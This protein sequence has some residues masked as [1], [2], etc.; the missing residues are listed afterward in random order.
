MVRGRQQ[1][2]RETAHAREIEARR[3][4]D[5]ERRETA[6]RAAVDRLLTRRWGGA[7]SALDHLSAVSRD[8]EKLHRDEARLLRDRDELVLW[9]RRGGQSWPMLSARTRL[10]RQALMKR[11]DSTPDTGIR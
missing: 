2:K 3:Q 4:E 1:A 10:S 11:M 6:E 5:R 7:S 8:L 9:L